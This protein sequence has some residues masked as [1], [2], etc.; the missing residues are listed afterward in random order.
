LASRLLSSLHCLATAAAATLETQCCSGMMRRR[1]PQRIC[2]RVNFPPLTAPQKM[3]P[4]GESPG[5]AVGRRQRRRPIVR[6]HRHQVANAGS[7]LDRVGNLQACWSSGS[8]STC[9]GSVPATT[10]TLR[11]STPAAAPQSNLRNGDGSF[12]LAQEAS[13]R[14][15]LSAAG[16]Y[17][18]NRNKLVRSHRVEGCNR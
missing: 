16:E 15:R 14:R 11:R 4:R 3:T 12:N 5:V 8:A 6:R 17:A 1:M 13:S 9:R 2:C 7:E 18:S 10:P